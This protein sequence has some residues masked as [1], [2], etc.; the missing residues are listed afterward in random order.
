MFAQFATCL[1][2]GCLQRQRQTAV[3]D[4]M[5]VR[6]K[7]RRGDPGFEVR[8]QSARLRPAQPSELDAEVALELE[9]EVEP[10]HVVARERHRERALG[11]VADRPAGRR[12]ELVTEGRPQALAF[13]V[14][15]EQSFLAGLGLE[16]RGQHAGC[17][18]RCAMSGLAALEHGDLA[19]GFGKT[20]ADAE[21]RHPGAN[22]GNARQSPSATGSVEHRKGAD[23][24]QT[25]DSL[26]WYDPGQVRWV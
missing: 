9:R 10:L 17:S 19:A 20:P 4:L 6:A 8:L 23:R 26:R 12:L 21:T 2:E 5:I 25:G 3:V 14:E 11:A 7:D 24:H 1:Q 16:T 15:R 22:D 13:Q 18:P